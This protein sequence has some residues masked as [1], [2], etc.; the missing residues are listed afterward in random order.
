[1]PERELNFQGIKLPDGF[2]REMVR[3]AARRA[4]IKEALDKRFGPDWGVKEIVAY[5]QDPEVVSRR[6]NT[7]QKGYLRTIEGRMSEYLDSYENVTPN[8]RT[9]FENMVGIEM[10]METIRVE[11]DRAEDHKEIESLTKSLQALSSEHRQIQTL[12]GI[13][14]AKRGE[15]FNLQR[16]LETYL[17]ASEKLIESRAA[18]IACRAC[19]AE[20]D[21]GLIL[22]HFADNTPWSFMFVCPRCGRLESIR[23]ALEFEQTPLTQGN[24][25]PDDLAGPI[26]VVDAPEPEAGP[27]L[28]LGS[29]EPAGDEAVVA[30][31]V[32]P[33]DPSGWADT[34]EA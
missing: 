19:Q 15:Q 1:M 7:K 8:D 31:E 32:H 29:P 3:T 11:L 28:G 17:D 13:G 27:D 16:E 33:F 9:M 18:K 2:S 4:K 12:L 14:R 10:R 26:L 20:I 30:A 24:A 23:G 22:Y 34:G 5:L 6:N 21:L 25:S